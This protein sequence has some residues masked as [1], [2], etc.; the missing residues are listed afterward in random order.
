MISSEIEEI[1]AYSDRVL[2]LR[3][4]SHVGCIEGEA[5]TVDGIVRAIADGSTTGA[6]A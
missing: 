5:V 6:A 4:R 2:V 1:V 3:D